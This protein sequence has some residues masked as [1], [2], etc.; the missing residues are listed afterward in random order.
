MLKNNA[1]VEC[2]GIVFALMITCIIII[3][4]FEPLKKEECT[5]EILAKRLFYSGERERER[6]I[7]RKRERERDRERER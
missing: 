4:G 2:I 3:T 7:E 5:S 6:E 1:Y